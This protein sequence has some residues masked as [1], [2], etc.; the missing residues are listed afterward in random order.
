MDNNSF[1]YNIEADSDKINRLEKQNKLLQQE[2]LKNNEESDRLIISL[3]KKISQKNDEYRK[4]V[5]ENEQLKIE[6]KRLNNK[7]KSASTQKNTKS[8]NVFDSF[9]GL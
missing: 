2:L 8:Y 1:F 4:V 5:Q 9:F 3:D 7:L 6:N